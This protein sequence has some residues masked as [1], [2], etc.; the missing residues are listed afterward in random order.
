MRK[1]LAILVAMALLIVTM[2]IAAPRHS[3]GLGLRVAEGDDDG[4]P[5]AKEPL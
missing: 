4:L 2:A 1:I 3:T 5:S